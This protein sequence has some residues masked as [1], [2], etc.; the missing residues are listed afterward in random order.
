MPDTLGGVRVLSVCAPRLRL[1]PVPVPFLVQTWKLR[2]VLYGLLW[3]MPIVIHVFIIE[4]RVIHY[5]TNDTELRAK[6]N[7]L[8]SL[9]TSDVGIVLSRGFRVLIFMHVLRELFDLLYCEFS[10]EI[11]D[12]QDINNFFFLHSITY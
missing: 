9:H 12:K 3:R 8:V 7:L 1:D 10:N 5:V 4:S 2:Q 11:I 6:Y